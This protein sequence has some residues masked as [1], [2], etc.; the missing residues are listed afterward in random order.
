MT[1]ASLFQKIGQKLG[2]NLRTRAVT[3][4]DRS[5]KIL[6]FISL[7]QD[8]DLLL[9]LAIRLHQGADYQVEVAVTD[10]ALAASPRISQLLNSAGIEP[11][12]LNHKAV[13]GGL[14]PRLGHVQA[15]VT[16][17]EST[18]NAHKGPHTLTHRAN[19]QGIPT[20][21][22]QHGFENVGI[23]YFDDE[24]PVGMIMFASKTIFIWGDVAQLPAIAPAETKAKCVSVGCPKFV[25][26]PGFN[27][28]VPGHQAGDRLIAVFENLHWSRYSDSYRQRFLHDLEQ[29]AIA[30]PDV[31][32]L[33]KPHHTGL[34][35][36]QRYQ[37]KLPVANNLIMA[38]PKAPEWE[39]FTAPALIEIAD[40]V[41]TTPSTVAIDAAR[42]GCPVAVVAYEMDL[43]NFEPL[44]LLRDGDEWRSLANGSNNERLSK[45]VEGFLGDPPNEALHDRAAASGRNRLISGDAVERIMHQMATDISRKR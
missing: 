8:L 43:P 28:E 4:T 30:C 11:T 18:A 17:S 31:T 1:Q 3:L 21:T 24:Y 14:Q 38:D 9:P 34:W 7:P 29:T 32:F 10:K 44:V 2:Q 35:L 12:V 26:A 41:I 16:A 37:G 19:Q 15:L 33:V 5:P 40:A 6:L 13:V 39:A 36:T 22:L 42:A 20:Y 27:V 45:G 25:D 23:T